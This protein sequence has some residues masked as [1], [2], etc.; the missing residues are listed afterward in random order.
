VW[1]G[2]NDAVLPSI[3]NGSFANLASTD[4]GFYGKGIYGTPDAEYAWRVYAKRGGVLL[5]CCFSFYS[6]YPVVGRQDMIKLKGKASYQ[7][8][9]AHAVPVVPDDPNSPV[10]INYFP[11]E[12]AAAALST[13]MELVVFDSPQALPR[14]IVDL[15]PSSIPRPLIPGVIAR[16]VPLQYA[17]LFA[18][19]AAYSPELHHVL[20]ALCNVAALKANAEQGEAQRK[21]RQR[22]IKALKIDASVDK[23][24]KSS[25][26]VTIG[27]EVGQGASGVV[28]RAEAHF[29][30]IQVAVKR[31]K[32]NTPQLEAAL[33]KEELVMMRVNS[34]FVVRIYGMLSDPLG[35]IMELVK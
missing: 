22:L 35:I 10:E 32:S 19:R 9:D 33:K 12:A 27:E 16:E 24:M 4:D 21:D 18:A 3:L 5:L 1:H 17:M 23:I 15:A 7:N 34:P 25:S 30:G 13:Y 2:T 31:L 11:A 20:A 28:Y 26:D 14:F 8:Y 6:A 29:M